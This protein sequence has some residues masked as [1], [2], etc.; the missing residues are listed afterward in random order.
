MLNTILSLFFKKRLSQ[1]ERF[2][3]HPF[4]AQE[5]WLQKLIS[6]GQYTCFGQAHHF[7]EIKTAAQFRE[8]VP[9]MPYEKIF[10]YIERS[11]RGEKNVLWPGRHM[12]FSKS[13]GHDQCPQQVYSRDE[14]LPARLSFQ[15]RPRFIFYLHFKLRILQFVERKGLGHRRQSSGKRMGPVGTKPLRRHFRHSYAMFSRVGTPH[16]LPLAPRGFAL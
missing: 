9:V 11:M 14:S 16:S 5:I 6:D 8:R 13:P 3:N 1:I 12:W 2:K 4:E 15:R 7:K 10:P